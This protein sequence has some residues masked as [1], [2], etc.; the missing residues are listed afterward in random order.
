MNKIKIKAKSISSDGWI[1]DKIE[2]NLTLVDTEIP[3]RSNLDTKT[4]ENKITRILLE[5]GECSYIIDENGYI[6][7]QILNVNTGQEAKYGLNFKQ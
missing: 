2:Q 5:I 3:I 4:F 1:I 6:K 7:D